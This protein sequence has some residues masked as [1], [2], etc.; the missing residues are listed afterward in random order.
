MKILKEAT[1]TRAV[2]YLYKNRKPDRSETLE[3]DKN[4]QNI[5]VGNKCRIKY[6]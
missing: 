1:V 5:F 3:T 2:L 4:I 6:W